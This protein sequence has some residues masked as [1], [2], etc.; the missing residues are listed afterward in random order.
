MRGLTAHGRS[1]LPLVSVTTVVYNGAEHLAKTISAVSE[2]TYPNV[3]HIVIDGG[4]TDGSV[5]I[6][7]ANDGTIGYWLSESDNG[8]YDAMNKG[9]GFVTDP[10]SY[11][12]FANSD[13]KLHSPGAIADAVAA[14]NGEDLIYGRMMLG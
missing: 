1:D 4:S 7:R 2:Q 11:V 12:I 9:I 5:D 8:I 13:D 6:I 3:E 10:S 14:A